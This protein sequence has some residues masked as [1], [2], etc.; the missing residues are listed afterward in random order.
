VTKRDQAARILV[1]EDDPSMRDLLERIL[2]DAG[3]EVVA[4]EDGLA[5]IARLK[6]PFDVVITDIRMPGADGI[7]V[8]AHARRRQPDLPVV[9]LTAFGSIPGAVDAMR[10]GAFDY[11]AKP[12]PDPQTLRDVVARALEGRPAGP[13]RVVVAED[14]AMQKVVETAR[15]VAQADSSVLLLGES[16]TGKEVIARLIHDASPRHEGPFVAVNCAALAETLLESELF[17]HEKGAFTGAQSRHEGQF[18]QAD[19]GTLMLDEVGE[20]SPA[21]QAKL[22]RVLQ[23]RSFQRVGGEAMISV[24]VRV[25]A[26]TNRDLDQMV[27]E[28]RFREDLYYRLAVLPIQ[29]P[30]LRERPKDVI[31]LAEHFVQ[32]LGRGRAERSRPELTPDARKALMAHDWPGNVRELQNVLERSLVLSGGGAVNA[33][34]LGLGERTRSEAGGEGGTLKDMERRAIQEAL[35]AEDGNRRRAAKRLGIALRTLQYKIKEYG[36]S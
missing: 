16:G 12:L 4:V 21:L 32:L 24:D 1:A 7:Q 8:L 15:R 29:I 36:L 13:S 3:H 27:K 19:G 11:L 34:D 9:V 33:A 25:V 10:L 14:P 31:P 5:A 26:A 20:M 6:G 17:G 28:G 23:E 30:P 22:L 2:S 35:A 18:E